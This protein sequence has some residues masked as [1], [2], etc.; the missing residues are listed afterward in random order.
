MNEVRKS[1]EQDSVVQGIIKDL[2]DNPNSHPHYKW[3]NY[4]LNRRG[5]IEVGNVEELKLQLISMYH[6]T[7][8]GRHFGSTMTAK[9]IGNLFY[10]KRL[11]KQ[12][13]QYVKEHSICQKNKTT[14]VKLQPLS[15]PQ[16]PFTDVSMDF[17]GLPKSYEKEVIFVV[18]DKLS[19]YR[20]FMVLS[21]PCTTMI[22]AT[23]FMENFYKLHGLPTT[24]VS[25]RDA[26][27][28]SQL[29]KHFFSY[30]GVQWKIALFHCLSSTN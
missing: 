17:I 10:W 20:H 22:V 12:G 2:Q 18:V 1:W 4:H 5:K 6:D 11:Q 25:N 24:I 15:I 7:A 29:W 16:F 8:M 23:S 27:F 21:H 9:K 30:P 28:L 26:M 3:V 19:K 14:C 13:R